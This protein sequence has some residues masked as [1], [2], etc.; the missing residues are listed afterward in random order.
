MPHPVSHCPLLPAQASELKPRTDR[1]GRAHLRVDWPPETVNPKRNSWRLGC[2][3][4][5]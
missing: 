1:E 5:R 2:R 4:Q 3:A